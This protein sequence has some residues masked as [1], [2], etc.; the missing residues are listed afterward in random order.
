MK[1]LT[2]A[3]V[4][5]DPE[6]VTFPVRLRDGTAL[7]YRPLVAADADALTAFVES[8]SPLTRSRWNLSGYDRV[9]AEEMIDAIARY[10]KLRLVAVDPEDPQLGICALFEFSFGIPRHECERYAGY[11][12]TLDEAHDCRFGPCVRDDMQRRG[13]A[14]ALM[15]PTLAIVRRF[16]KSRVILWGGV[17]A[18]NAPAIAFYLRHGFVELGRFATQD[19]L[20]SIDMLREV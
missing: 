16:G 5:A 14:S 6:R 9:A 7:E 13:L 15:P 19:G 17:L 11:G 12:I 3:A 20:S 2:L 8:L 18:T 4:A 10:D 1:L